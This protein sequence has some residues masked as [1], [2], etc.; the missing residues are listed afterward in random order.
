MMQ[1]NQQAERRKVGEGCGLLVGI[2]Q[3]ST[4][5]SEYKLL[6]ST[7]TDTWIAQYMTG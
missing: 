2:E 4:F 1:L 6:D 5:H 7:N 3:V